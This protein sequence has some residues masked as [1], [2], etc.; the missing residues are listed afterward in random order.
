MRIGTNMSAII[1][2]R[3][4]SKS[5]KS[6]KTSLERL[7]SGYKINSSKD[8]S[9][10]MAISEKMRTQI[11]NLNRASMN[12]SDGISVTQTAE[13]AL[14]EMHSMLQRMNELAVQGANDTCTDEDRKNINSEID[15]LK[16]EID[17]IS[18]DTEFNNTK[19]LNGD[20]QRRAYSTIENSS[21]EKTLTDAVST[22]YI[23]NSATA[24]EYGITVNA[25]GT[26]DF[27]KDTDGNRIGFSDSAVMTAHNYKVRVTDVDGFEMEFTVNPE[28]NFAGDVTVE[29]WDLGTMPI[30][31]GA[32]ANQ[33]MNIG[34]P[35]VSTNSLNLDQLDFSTSD[36]CGEAITTINDAISRVSKIRSEL[37]AYQNRLEYSVS[38]LDST[39]ENMTSALSRITDVDMAEE[40]TNYTQYNVLQQAGVS[41]VAQ[42]NQLPEKVLQLLQ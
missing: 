3:Y 1:S 39:Q 19:L 17:R 31:V 28:A 20:V 18:R 6:L 2:N 10:G 26:A 12:A 8:D 36:T 7:S 33:T 23:T 35:E 15:A 11:K 22:T 37:G 13:G 14:S 38:S 29:L 4:L 30:Q 24:A 16:K 21:G 41:M 34:I 32:N 25:D 27:L 9:A 40:M 42:A 5:E